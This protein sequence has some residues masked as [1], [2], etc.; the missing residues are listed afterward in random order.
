M[1]ECGRE[2][3]CAL[4]VGS[5][6]PPQQKF[7][8]RLCRHDVERDFARPAR[9]I[10]KARRDQQAGARAGHQPLDRVGAFDVVVDEEPRPPPGGELRQSC[11]GELL[12]VRRLGDA[13]QEGAAQP[14]V[15]RGGE[16]HQASDQHGPVLGRHPPHAGIVAAEAVCILAGERAFADAAEALQSRRSGGRLGS[17]QRCVQL[18]EE[19][20]AADEIAVSRRHAVNCSR[21]RRQRARLP[22]DGREDDRT[23]LVRVLDACQVAV[24]MPGQ[25]AAGLAILDAQD[26]QAPLAVGPAGGREKIR[27]LHHRELGVGVIRG[28]Q[29]DE[30]A[31][32]PQRLVD[33]GD[34]VLAL[35]KVMILQEDGIA[36][37]FQYLGDLLR[38]CAGRASARYEKIDGP[39]RDGRRLTTGLSTGLR[40]NRHEGPSQSTRAGFRMVQD[41]AARN[42]QGA[43]W[44]GMSRSVISRA[45]HGHPTFGATDSVRSLPRLRG[46]VGE[47]VTWL[48]MSRRPMPHAPRG[49][50]Q[51]GF[52]SPGRALA[53]S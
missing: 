2:L 7:G 8:C 28:Q 30:I 15:D 3:G 42:R 1:P 37:L 23:A 25:H 32:A 16:L 29:H 43:R 38:G 12:E 40:L 18:R 6:A 31:A 33:G 47:G 52:S 13:R 36:V 20:V 24:D 22:C 48:G 39:C 45:T 11:S 53:G 4:P 21:W 27:Q 10:G 5:A 46:R 44:Q 17:Q 49:R 35:P 26:D 14:V 51:P 9:P 50:G 41:A 19:V 34:E